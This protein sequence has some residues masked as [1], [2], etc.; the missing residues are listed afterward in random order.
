[1]FGYDTWAD[2]SL[3]VAYNYHLTLS[4]CLLQ[5]GH[6][7]VRTKFIL[8]SYAFK[9]EERAYLLISVMLLLWIKKLDERKE[10]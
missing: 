1:M 7:K 2:L 9:L 10:I 5:I 3:L 6:K 8:E 4:S